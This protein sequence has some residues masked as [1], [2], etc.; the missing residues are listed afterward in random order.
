MDVADMRFGLFDGWDTSDA[1]AWI[2]QQDRGGTSMKK[3]KE[4]FEIED[5]EDGQE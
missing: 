5:C 3:Q 2:L 4:A 1:V